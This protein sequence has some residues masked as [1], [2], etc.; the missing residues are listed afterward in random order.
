MCQ[1]CGFLDLA[2]RIEVHLERAISSRHQTRILEMV[3]NIIVANEHVT[4]DH[5]NAIEAVLEQREA[6]R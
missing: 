4:A 3:R 6:L 5:V 1:T 2:A